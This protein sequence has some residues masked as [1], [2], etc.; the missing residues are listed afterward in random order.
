MARVCEPSALG[1]SHSQAAHRRRDL[2]TLSHYSSIPETTTSPMAS[3]STALRPPATSLRACQNGPGRVGSRR[4]VATKD[5][6]L[7][8]A[9][10]ERSRGYCAGNRA[11]ELPPSHATSL[12]HRSGGRVGEASFGSWPSRWRP[13][14]RSNPAVNDEQLEFERTWRRRVAGSSFAEISFPTD[15]GVLAKGA[16]SDWQGAFSS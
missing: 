14:G 6:R 15:C 1:G 16:W 13:S 10:R 5:C 11:H 4:G 7:L 9:L 3:R 2:S 8:R 12:L